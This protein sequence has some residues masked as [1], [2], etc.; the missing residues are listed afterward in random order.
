MYPMFV[1]RV[2]ARQGRNMSSLRFV[3]PAVV[4]ASMLACF[5]GGEVSTEPAD[6]LL[7][8]GDLPGGAGA[9]ETLAKDHPDSVSV[10]V[11]KAYTEYLAGN[12]EAAD[13]TLA[14][15]EAGAGE[16]V[17]EIKLRRAMVALAA[18]NL[19]DVRK[20]GKESGLPAGLVMAAE[21]HLADAEAEDA[22]ELLK[23]ARSD[24]GKVGET[25]TWY[26]EKIESG[27]VLQAGLAEAAALWAV[28]QRPT[29]CE[30]AED[31]VKGLPEEGDKS[32]QL[33]DWAG[34]AVTSGRPGIAS[35]LLDE[36]GVVGAPPGQEWRVEATRAIVLIADGQNEE[37]VEKFTQL[38]AAVAAGYAPWEG[39][40]DARATAAA[41]T[42]DKEV[43]KT[44]LTGIQTAPA[45][46][47]LFQAGAPAVARESAPAG[48]PI[49]SFLENQ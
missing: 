6:S 2:P 10:A 28:G 1:N 7:K 38:E 23:T 30:V 4:L 43:A 14:A 13:K 3:P 18:G 48:T 26:L 34:R 8:S 5:G 32:A 49:A 29:A 42:A 17:G 9:Y 24:S 36:L 44:L 22:I 46:R 21:V 47:A 41:L 16:K 25:A 37:G 40:A 12:F 35:S 33:L 19:D 20:H 27:D 15:A 11:G 31:L 39:V 45:A